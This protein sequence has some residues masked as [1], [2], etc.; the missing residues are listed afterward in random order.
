MTR[1]AFAVAAFFLAACG[2][3]EALVAGE[4][5]PETAAEQAELTR[6]PT[7]TLF[8]KQAGARFV[9]ATV[10]RRKVVVKGAP[11]QD[12]C[13]ALWL[14]DLQ[15]KTSKSLGGERVFCGPF[16]L[17]P[18]VSAD[19]TR[20]AAWAYEQPANAWH[21]YLWTEAQP[22]LEKIAS[23]TGHPEG[24]EL[25][26]LAFSADGKHLVYVPGATGPNGYPLFSYAVDTGVATRVSTSASLVT[27]RM[28]PDG[29]RM[30]F[31]ADGM[32]TRKVMAW[33]FATRAAAVL[34]EGHDWTL[35]A[36]PDQARV[37]FTAACADVRGEG[38]CELREW[39]FTSAAPRVVARD[40]RESFGFAAKA[41]V[42]A[43]RTS[44]GIETWNAATQ[45][46]SG[47][48]GA[49][50]AGL[51]GDGAQLA[52]LA[53]CSGVPQAP[54]GE[55][56]VGTT[57]PPSTSK[58]VATNVQRGARGFE[59]Q[60]NLDGSRLTYT[61]SN[62]ELMLWTATSSL[63]AR[64]L[65]KE[66]MGAW[67]GESGSYLFSPDGKQLVY[68]R[69][70]S[71]VNP[72][73]CPPYGTCGYRD[74]VSRDVGSSWGSDRTVAAGSAYSSERYSGFVGG[75][76][77]ISPDGALIAYLAESFG[78]MRLNALALPSRTA[79]ALGKSVGGQPLAVVMGDGF[80]A[81]STAQ[82]VSVVTGL[83]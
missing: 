5:A 36:S 41:G 24:N 3:S 44:A 14:L 47:V 15:L 82:G 1:S 62:R 61:G 31:L 9:G 53:S 30:V 33:T 40:V 8:F 18:A 55:L 29:A 74:L 25:T 69:I 76:W 80:A 75:P 4:D 65:A 77:S 42:L 21:L 2:P 37:V 50:W 45:Q 64:Q 78:T 54:A 72:W 83:K 63:S 38:S 56:R 79:W 17:S 13:A 49:C 70:T 19:G 39:S 51:S 43:W 27:P 58:R 23:R 10:D 57:A 60:L 28:S 22:R 67:N 68:E 52:W 11:D 48:T 46:R 26:L 35:Q 66:T 20:V 16:T 6:T 34:G 73:M 7:S 32:S 81:V 12:D 59:P 71:W